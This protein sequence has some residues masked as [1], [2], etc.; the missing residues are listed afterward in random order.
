MSSEPRLV[1]LYGPPAVGKLTV[2]SALSAHTGMPLFH[3]HLTVD[4]IKAVFEFASP[5]FSEVVHRIRLDVFETAMRHGIDLIFTN[6]SVWG[7]PDGRRLFASFAEEA[8][9]RVELAGGRVVFVQLT[10]PREV[11][12]ERVSSPSRHDQRKLVDPDR[13]RELLRQLDPEPLHDDDLVIDTAALDPETAA[14]LIAS[15][16]GVVRSGR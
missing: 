2:A 9:R 14:G 10:A 3:N 13:L 5:A 8:R 16:L 12:E 6:N 7:V 15:R 1:Y 11:L 4:A